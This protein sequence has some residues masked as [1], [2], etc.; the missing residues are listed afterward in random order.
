MNFYKD[1]PDFRITAYVNNRLDT[2]H[3]AL[4][5]FIRNDK[6]NVDSLESQQIPLV[7]EN[8]GEKIQGY[9]N[10]FVMKDVMSVDLAISV[11]EFLKDI[12]FDPEIKNLNDIDNKPTNNIIKEFYKQDDHKKIF[13]LNY[14]M[15]SE[16]KQYVEKNFDQTEIYD[17]E[18]MNDVIK[19]STPIKPT[20]WKWE[21]YIDGIFRALPLD[22]ASFYHSPVWQLI[23]ILDKKWKNT[24]MTNININA[25]TK[26]TWVI[27]RIPQG[28]GIDPHYDHNGYRKIAFAYYLTDDD[29]N[30]DDGGDL[31][32]CNEDGTDCMSFAPIFNSLVGWN[33][34]EDK[35]PLHFVDKVKADNSKPRIALVGFY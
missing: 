30:Y 31:R 8:C 10:V 26:S 20:Q 34:S 25:L 33:M 17:F 24:Q 22:L 19:N 35:S 12:P 28:F 29:W 14:D 21:K 13:D 23:S 27:Q 4:T 18:Y 2:L 7:L 6:T 16:R 5:G 15:C 32:V 1:F 11:R 9:S 3:N